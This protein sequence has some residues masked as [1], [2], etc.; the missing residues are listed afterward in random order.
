[1]VNIKN[2]TILLLSIF[3]IG[4]CFSCASVP[5]N[6][7]PLFQRSVIIEDQETENQI[8]S[9][10]SLEKIAD[11][12]VNNLK[13]LYLKGTP[14]EMG[15]QHGKL[16][17]ED[18]QANIHRVI[19]LAKIFAS[20]DIMDET[21]DL[22]APYIPIEEKEEMRGLAHG[23]D[24]PL[25]VVH[26]FHTIPEISEYGP[27][28]KFLKQLKQ[29]SCSNIATFGKSTADGE[30]YHLRVLD[31]IRS[32]GVQ[33]RPVIIVHKPNSGNAS[34]TFSFAGF[35]GCVSGM[36]EKM[37]TFGE[38]GYGDP[39]GESLEGIPFVFLFRKLMREADT[40][41]DAKI[42][43]ND[44][45]RTCSYVYMITDAKTGNDF[46]NALLFITNRNSVRVFGENTALVD[47]RDN[48]ES[49]PI[50]DVVYGGA[51]MEESYKVISE[52]YGKISPQIL[53]KISKV[54]SLKGN[55]QNVIF[56][57]KTLEAWVSNAANNTRD[58]KGKACNQ[59]WFH[60]D[61]RKALMK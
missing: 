17:K 18:V 36:N 12:N 25:K 6:D 22:I 31:W 52:H 41:N 49:P 24:I 26:W 1:M 3:L 56:K 60:F 28:R 55:M 38:M 9:N 35:I 16:L 42:I 19:G 53:I 4:I 46:P 29:T 48:E 34:A 20:E 33:K 7:L 51:K 27:K 59:H 54:I 50:D 45:L 58:E 8:L 23:A 44:A 61:F 40:L 43:I 13:I 2:T 21:Y 47:E 14:Y 32:M 11:P 37:M 5:K 15:F 30:M 57:P 39:P 10:A